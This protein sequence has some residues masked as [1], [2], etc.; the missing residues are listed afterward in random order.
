MPGREG[1]STWQGWGWTVGAGYDF[2][3]VR[4]MAL[5]PFASFRYG[6]VGD[7][8]PFPSEFLTPEYEELLSVRGLKH[9]VT[10]L[11][12]RVTVQ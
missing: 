7:V 12:L 6:S 8:T 10:E 2:W 11:G 1:I 4:R 9:Q 5:T 3:V